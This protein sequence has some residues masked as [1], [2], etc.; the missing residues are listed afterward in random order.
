MRL[1]IRYECDGRV[2]VGRVGEVVEDEG[3][4]G[5]ARQG[6]RRRPR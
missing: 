1:M 6:Q 4:D 2:Y 3:P 5:V